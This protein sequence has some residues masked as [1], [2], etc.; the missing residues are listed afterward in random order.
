MDGLPPC[1][2]NILGDIHAGFDD[3]NLFADILEKSIK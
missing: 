3:S 1:L 2:G